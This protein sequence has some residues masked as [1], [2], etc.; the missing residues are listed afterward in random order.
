MM[1]V[2]FVER[3]NDLLGAIG[4]S[5]VDYGAQPLKPEHEAYV[6]DLAKKMNIKTK[7]DFYALPFGHPMGSHCLYNK[8]FIDESLF[9]GDQDGLT[10]V[11]GHELMHAEKYHGLSRYAVFCGTCLPLYYLLKHVGTRYEIG[12]KADETGIPFA[13]YLA[14]DYIPSLCAAGCGWLAQQVMAR[15]C[16]RE[17]DLQALERLTPHIGADKIAQGAATILSQNCSFT[18]Y[19]RFQQVMLDHPHP[20]ERL[21][22]LGIKEEDACVYADTFIHKSKTTCLEII[23]SLVEDGI[24]VQNM[25][26][27]DHMRWRWEY[28]ELKTGPLRRLCTIY[29]SSIKKI[30]VELSSENLKTYM[31][32]AWSF[33]VDDQHDESLLDQIKMADAEKQRLK[34]CVT[35]GISTAL[36]EEGVELEKTLIAEYEKWADQTI[37][38]FEQHLQK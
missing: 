32:N 35:K 15:P 34:D 21:R 7:V 18:P 14:G 29:P 23:A 31:R 5:V 9:K 25:P 1:S 27:N 37:V 24:D 2:S 17:A 8:I 19:T 3:I 20:G 16:E 13:G 6:R 26:W 12:K 38:W 10:F 30:M 33:V 28:F 11:V 4:Q 22:Y 36:K